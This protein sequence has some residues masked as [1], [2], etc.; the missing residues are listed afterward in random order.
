MRINV[1]RRIMERKRSV[2]PEIQFCRAAK[3]SG[4][5]IARLVCIV[6]FREGVEALA[7]PLFSTIRPG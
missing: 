7:L 4:I 2:S 1:G 6:V 3:R 5:V